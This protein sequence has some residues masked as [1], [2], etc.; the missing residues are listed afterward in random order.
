[1]VLKTIKTV[2]GQIGYDDRGESNQ[3][4][5]LL[6]P[7]LFSDHTMWDQQ[8]KALRDAGWRTLALDPPGHGSSPGPGRPFTMNECTDVA[9]QLLGLVP[10]GVP[11]VMLGTSWGGMIAPRVAHRFPDRLKGIVL[12]NTTADRP[13]LSTKATARLLTV[14]LA[15]A[16]LDG[17]VDRMLLSLQISEATHQRDP[18]MV[19]AF[20]ARF[21]SWNRRALIG[22]VDSVLVRRDAFFDELAT[23]ATPALVV[24]GAQDTIRPTALSR[25]IV[26]RMPNAHQIEV[27]GAAHLVPVEQPDRANRLILD[28]LADLE[29]VRV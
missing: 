10:L 12:F 26:E 21:R 8:V 5:A 14:L 11:V 22:S 25:R 13:D 17:I 16:P 3:P 19:R 1:M 2:L 29:R 27:E 6:W 7:S 20:A 28:F 9:V 4:T 18:K 24:S 23:I 15:I